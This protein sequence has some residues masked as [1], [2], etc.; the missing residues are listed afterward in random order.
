MKFGLS[1]EEYEILNTLCVL[2]LKGLNAEVWI[3]GSRARHEHNPTSDIDILYKVTPPLRSA[4]LGKISSALEESR[5]P[6][7]VDLVNI[8]NLADSY[9]DAVL[10]ERIKL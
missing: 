6:Y 4:L 10:E 3:F 7:K 9:K 2:P 8:R 1:K 5:L